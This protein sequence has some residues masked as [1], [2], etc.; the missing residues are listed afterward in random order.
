MKRFFRSFSTVGPVLAA[1]LLLT[2]ACRGPQTAK[3]PNVL[4]L[5]ADDQRADTIAALGNLHIQTPNLD[6]LVRQ[7]TVCTRAYCMGAMQGEVC[8]PSRAMI[9]S[10]RSLFR[11]HTDLKDQDTWPEAFG[12]AGYR[13]FMTGKWHNEGES[14]RRSFEVGRAVFFG[15]MGNPYR[16]PVEDF[17]SHGF[18]NKRPSGKHA[19]ELFA[20]TAIDF[21][22][23]QTGDRPFLCYVAFTTPHD[24]RVVPKEYH[25]HYNADQPPLPPNYLPVHP[26]NNGD[27][28]GRDE[29]LAPWPRTPEVVRQ[30]LA[31]YYASITFLDAQ[32][33][34]I[35][36]ALK[37][38]GQAENT[39]VVYSSDHGLAIGSHGL[40]GKQNLYD[41]SMHSPLL[42]IGPGIPYGKQVDALC[43]LLDIF[44]TLGDLAGVRGPDGSE[45]VS[46]A[47]VLT[48]KG[49][50]PRSSIFTAYKDVQRAVRDDRWKLI[51]YPKINKVQ[52]FDL[53]DGMA[54]KKNASGKDRP[55]PAETHDL[56]VD[57]DHAGE[58]QRLTDLL[59]DWQQQL[60]DTLPL[61]S[62]R[63]EP[64]AF[65]FSKV[66]PEKKRGK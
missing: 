64:A 20:D 34:R 25:E 1:A 2:T 3:R 29:R 13:T 52:L 26:F 32:V 40:F 30:H 21:L 8:V 56:S 62:D 9:M 65:D 35:L 60:G 53:D 12:K 45:G 66:P 47:P 42:F 5:L 58:V 37:E 57:S 15:G 59:K 24:P 43:Y 51:V 27:P 10:G 14:A 7:G 11:A 61:T 36:E 39:L 55:D 23:E 16:L 17:D 49:P 63:P 44:P 50:G 22:K 6:R 4:F 38:S 18:T 28:I 31:D 33:G 41:H 46:L 48:G 19:A 54:T